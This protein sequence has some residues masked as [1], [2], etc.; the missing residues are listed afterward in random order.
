M[1]H[2]CATSREKGTAG[3]NGGVMLRRHMSPAETHTWHSASAVASSL[4]GRQAFPVKA[5]NRLHAGDPPLCTGRRRAA[6]WM[7]VLACRG[8][9]APVG[10]TASCSR[11]PPWSSGRCS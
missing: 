7:P 5:G 2:P 9:G 4:P 11:V 10:A 6:W 1:V 3:R 8:L